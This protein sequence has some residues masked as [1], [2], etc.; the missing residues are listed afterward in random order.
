MASALRLPAA[1]RKRPIANRPQGANLP[2]RLRE[3][4]I[5]VHGAAMSKVAVA[6]ATWFGCGYLP[7][8]PGTAGSLAALGIAYG[9]VKTAGWRPLHFLALALV[10]LPIGV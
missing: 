3:Q 7:V 6:F 5:V 4:W 10:A 9:L 8:G 2:Y 1:R